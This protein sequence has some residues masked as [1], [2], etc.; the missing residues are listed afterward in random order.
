MSDVW[1]T[2]DRHFDHKN[3][4]KFCKRPFIDERYPD[5]GDQTDKRRWDHEAM[6]EAMITYNN[7]V[8]KPNDVVYDLGDFTFGRDASLD[9]CRSFLRRL[10]GRL[11][12]LWGNHDKMVKEVARTNP[13]L[14]SWFDPEMGEDH[15]PIVEFKQG[16]MVD[17]ILCHYAMRVWNHSHKGSFHL[18]GHSHGDL[19]EDPNSLSFDVGV[20]CTNFRPMHLDEVVAKM[21][22]KLKAWK[23][24]YQIAAQP[25][26]PIKE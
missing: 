22:K 24:P 9:R 15:N 2:S 5:L 16:K 23:P 13:E 18:Y 26:I 20:D 4:I 19:P 7:E 25:W 8:V 12:F 11:H 14:F 10:N 1:F 6:N 21:N 17:I 3:I